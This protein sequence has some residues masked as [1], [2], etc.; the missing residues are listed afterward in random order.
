M[1]LSARCLKMKP[2]LWKYREGDW[3]EMTLESINIVTLKPC[4]IFN[5]TNLLISLVLK[6]NGKIFLNRMFH[7][8]LYKSLF[9]LL[10]LPKIESTKRKWPWSYF[11]FEILPLFL[12]SVPQLGKRE[13]SESVCFWMRKNK[14]FNF[15][16]PNWK[17]KLQ[18][19]SIAVKVPWVDIPNE[20]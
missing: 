14:Y 19:E 12:F 18:W 10:V 9:H 6:P 15:H 3:V 4:S 13:W 2:T 20:L 11:L 5:A 1:H 8:R 17:W 16:F 7:H